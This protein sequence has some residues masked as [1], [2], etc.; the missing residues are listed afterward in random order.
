MSIKQLFVKSETHSVYYLALSTKLN[1][2]KT[3]KPKDE[4][5]FI[6]MGRNS[7]QEIKKNER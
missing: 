5:L 6:T 2:T 7:K 1:N 4:P 3:K